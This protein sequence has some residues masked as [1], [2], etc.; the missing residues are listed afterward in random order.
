MYINII[1]LQ[2]RRLLK[3]LLPPFRHEMLGQHP[4]YEACFIP[5]RIPDLL[6]SERVVFHLNSAVAFPSRCS[7]RIELR[8]LF[9]LAQILIKALMSWLGAVVAFLISCH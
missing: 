5:F 6:D 4:G 8:S 7:G 3:Q 2:I 9:R 1:W